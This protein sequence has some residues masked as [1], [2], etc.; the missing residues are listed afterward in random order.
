MRCRT[1]LLLGLFLLSSSAARA[2]DIPEASPNA[3]AAHAEGLRAYLAEDYGTAMRQ[4]LRAHELDHTFY[5]PLFMAAITSGNAGMTA[6]NDS[7][8]GVVAENRARFSDYYRRLIDIYVLRRSGGDWAESMRMSKAVAD[9]YPGTKAAYNF[10]LWSNNDGRPAQAL[11]AL[12]TLDPDREPMKGWFSYYA[13]KCSALHFTGRYEEE[14]QCGRDA[15]ERFPERAAPTWETARAL[16]AL[17]RVDEISRVLEA[18][19]DLDDPMIG[20]S[21]GARYGSIG[22][23]LLAHGGDPATAKAYLEKAVSWYAALPPDQAARPALRRQGAYWLY[24][25]GRY[26]EAY[27]GMQGIVTDLGS[28]WDRGY[29]GITAALAGDQPAARKVLAAFEG[30]EITPTPAVMHYW[31]GLISA[32]LGEVDA[33]A[34]HLGQTWSGAGDHS[35]PV[36]RLKMGDHPAFKAFAA[37]RG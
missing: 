21:L 30:G 25:S 7:L 1:L 5:V 22:T 2:Q 37:P 26:D 32:A 27:A 17:G 14:L 28:V 3:I 35:E 10:A 11:V 12:G 8:W 23:E 33:A 20:Y 16:A 31:A 4:F 18:G 34:A 6:V 29:L 15:A 24:A 36:L 19:A 9:A 13:V